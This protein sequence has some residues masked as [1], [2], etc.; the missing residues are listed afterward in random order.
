MAGSAR[1]SFRTLSLVVALVAGLVLLG[2]SAVMADPLTERRTDADARVNEFELLRIRTE[3]A[4]VHRNQLTHEILAPLIDTPPPAPGPDQIAEVVETSIAELEVLAAEANATGFAAGSLRAVLTEW[5]DFPTVAEDELWDLMFFTDMARYEGVQPAPAE[6]LEQMLFYDADVAE[7]L[8]EMAALQLE[9]VGT[10]DP[11]LADLIDS[12]SPNAFAEDFVDPNA[13]SEFGGPALEADLNFYGWELP[14]T[15]AASALHAELVAMVEATAVADYY[16]HLEMALATGSVHT[17]AEFDTYATELLSLI[18]GIRERIDAELATQS[19]VVLADRSSVDGRATL[20]AWLRNV[21]IG[22][23]AVACLASLVGMIRRGRTATRQMSIDPLTGI[24]NRRT[25]EL[26]QR[27]LGDPH[28][29]HHLVA[30]IDLDRFK[31]VNDTH[32]HAVGDELLVLV[33]QGLQ[34]IADD[35]TCEEST[36]LRQGGDEFLLSLHS[37]SPIDRVALGDRLD[38]LR[39]SHVKLAHGE[40]LAL[41]FSYGMVTATGSPD[42]ASI[43]RSA[44]LAAYEDKADRRIDE[45]VTDLRQPADEHASGVERPAA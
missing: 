20:V 5:T 18:D 28:H 45:P 11:L 44:D 16:R 19:G 17:P 35:S 23:L 29:H 34:Q 30:V 42:M 13:T 33:A 24:G 41:S 4:R 21:G 39:A 3:L 32:G 31:L 40:S 15:P 43:I 38:E 8:H 36:V 12:I 1:I 9:V 27:N 14:A 26:T 10:D 37:S 6:T 22:L 7:V 25:L 2:V